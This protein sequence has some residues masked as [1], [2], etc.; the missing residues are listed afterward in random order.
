MIQT[1]TVGTDMDILSTGDISGNFEICFC[2]TGQLQF[3]W[4]LGATGYSTGCVGTVLNDNNWH[5]VLVTYDGTTLTLYED[6]I[7]QYTTNI[8]PSEMNTF[9]NSYNAIGV[10]YIYSNFIGALNFVVFYDYVVSYSN[11][12][13]L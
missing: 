4:R 6:G 13:N 1:T 7:F 2:T 12:N 11:G 5:T 10:G 8:S 9:G 3:W